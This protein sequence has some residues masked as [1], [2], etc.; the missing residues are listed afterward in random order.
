VV[1]VLLAA[2]AVAWPRITPVAVVVASRR[3][4]KRKELGDRYRAFRSRRLGETKLLALFLEAV[5]L[6]IRPAV[7]KDVLVAWGYTETGERVL[8][9]V[10]LGR[11]ERHEDWL[12]MGERLVRRSLQPP[13]LVV[14]D[15]TPGL[16]RAAERVWSTS[17]RQCCAVHLLRDL[18]R[19]LPDH[20]DLRDR[21]RSGYWAALDEACSEG[22]A[23]LRMQSLVEGLKGDHP[24]AAASLAE[25]L[26]ALSVHL[27]YPLALRKQ[28]RSTN[29]WENREGVVPRRARLIDRVAGESDCLRLSWAVLDLVV[30]GKPGPDPTRGITASR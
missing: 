9:D 6:P 18:L 30:A 27:R 19:D 21:V 29:L 13:R 10:C 14:A 25:N 17:D 12:A 5:R 22:Q 24:G 1:S 20:Q 28:L 15:G 11:N 26:P 7:A 2:A 4:R 23:Q 8:L 16:T 3:H